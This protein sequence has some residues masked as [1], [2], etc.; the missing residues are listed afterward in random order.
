MEALP[1]GDIKEFHEKEYWQKFYQQEEVLK[2]HGFE[3]YAEYEEIKD[4][5]D[6]NFKLITKGMKKED[7]HVLVPG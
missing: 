3:W 7:A 4:M 5:L 6:D 2:Q 1:K